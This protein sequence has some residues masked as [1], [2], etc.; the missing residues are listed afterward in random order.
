[1]SCPS[2]GIKSVFQDH[3]KANSF[4]SDN[5]GTFSMSQMVTAGIYLMFTY[6]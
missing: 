5:G 3:F 4:L 6:D 2:G 1:M